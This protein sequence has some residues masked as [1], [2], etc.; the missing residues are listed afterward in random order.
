ML[1][2][3]PGVQGQHHAD[4]VTGVVLSLAGALLG[5]WAMVDI[6]LSPG[7]R[8]RWLAITGLAGALAGLVVA[9]S[10]LH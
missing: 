1:A 6:R 4:F 5:V 7:M 8:G 2:N 9:L 10:T 3:R